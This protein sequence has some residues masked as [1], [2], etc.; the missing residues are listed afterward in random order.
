MDIVARPASITMDEQDM[1]SAIVKEIKADRCISAGRQE[2]FLKALKD[3][4]LHC[5]EPKDTEKPKDPEEG[6]GG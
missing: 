4:F 2:G 6:K 5:E 3:F 1:Y